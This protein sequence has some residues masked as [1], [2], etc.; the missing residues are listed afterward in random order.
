MVLWLCGFPEV[1]KLCGLSLGWDNFKVH[2]GVQGKG[3]TWKSK[4]KHIG[5]V[6]LTFNWTFLRLPLEYLILLPF[7]S[8][9]STMW[10]T[11]EMMPIMNIVL[12]GLQQRISGG[13]PGYCDLRTGRPDFAAHSKWRGVSAQCGQLCRPRYPRIPPGRRRLCEGKGTRWQDSG[14][15]AT[16]VHR[17]RLLSGC[18]KQ[19]SHDGEP[20]QEVG[21]YSKG[22]RSI[23]KDDQV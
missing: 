16:H 23:Q 1:Q 22:F 15:Q 6:S 3:N 5:V 21:H 19:Q 11:C 9:P 4:I 13:G 2:N 17:A 7:G 8:T 12:A 18:P 20:V 14:Q 10:T